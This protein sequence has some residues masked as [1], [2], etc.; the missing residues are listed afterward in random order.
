MNLYNNRR[1]TLTGDQTAE[2]KKAF[3]MVDTNRDGYIDKSEV[4]K[5]LMG[6][7]DG[8]KLTD[9]QLNEFMRNADEDG[10]G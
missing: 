9:T 8:N 1:S 5:M 7:D 3:D 6:L 10:D 2:L 4:R